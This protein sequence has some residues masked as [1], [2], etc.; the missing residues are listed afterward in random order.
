MVGTLVDAFVLRVGPAWWEVSKGGRTV[1]VL[2]VLWSFPP[3]RKW[4]DNGLKRRLKSAR[5][6]LLPAALS[7]GTGGVVDNSLPPSDWDKLPPELTQRV[8]AAA[9]KLGKPASRYLGRPPLVAGYLLTSDFRES[10]GLRPEALMAQVAGTI[11]NA[12]VLAR[13]AAVLPVDRYTKGLSGVT[14]AAG[15]ACVEAA[16]SEVETG[17]EPLKASVGAWAVGDVAAA[18]A[19]P[20]GLE[21][22]GFAVPGQAGLRRAA[23]DAQVDAI[24]QAL[25]GETGAGARAQYVALANLRTLVA[26]DGVLDKLRRRGYQVRSPPE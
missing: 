2:G 26:E 25:D 6:V 16:L 9:G 20:R 13:N 19:A 8:T 22:C 3:D 23:I 15:Q 5:A 11:R 21:L 1:H 4:N 10:L 18:L 24:A 17:E 7:E 14:S 12:G